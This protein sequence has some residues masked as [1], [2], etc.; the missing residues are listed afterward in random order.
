MNLWFERPTWLWWLLPMLAMTVFI[1]LGGRREGKR[2]REALAVDAPPLSWIRALLATIG[3]CLLLVA[4]AGPRWGAASDVATAHRGDVMLVLD[5]SR[6]MLARDAMPD[7]LLRG[8]EIF[9]SLINQLD[10]RGGWRVGLVAFAGQPI[11]LCP[12]TFDLDFVRQRLASINFDDLGETRPANAV[13]GTRIGAAIAYAS[14]AGDGPGA[15]M[16]LV[17]DGDDPVR[18][19]EWADGVQAARQRNIP[20]AVIGVGNAQTASAIPGVDAQSKMNVG[21]L[22]EIAQ[23]THGVF[24]E[25]QDLHVDS[26]V[27]WLDDQAVTRD[28]IMARSRAPARPAIFIAGGLLA[29]ILAVAPWPNRQAALGSVA[30]LAIAANPTEKWVWRGNQELA[31]G[32]AEQALRWYQIAEERT[33][34]PGLVAFNEGIAFAKLERWRDAELYFRRS[35]SDAEGERRFGALYNLGTSLIRRSMGRDRQALQDAIAALE[36]AL[37]LKPG[38]ADAQHNLKLARD[39]LAQV[40]A[41]PPVSSNND[42][43][44]QQA[45][46]KTSASPKSPVLKNGNLVGEPSGPATKSAEGDGGR[47]T[48]RPPPPGQGNLPMIPDTD[49][50]ERITPED[51]QRH[52]DRAAARIAAAQRDQLKSR[53][54][55]SKPNYPDW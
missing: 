47:E 29:I 25:A 12:L 18:D 3:A 2:R 36:Q 24:F 1:Y 5:V 55:T 30:L 40:P 45:N 8:V 7:R 11:T 26:I 41:E 53:R 49:V 31:A 32:R 38:D 42:Q 54:P 20:I 37:A 35:L 48:D 51:L 17:S 19:G 6:S 46:V 15:N 34:D 52:L 39:L 14:A 9:G 44:K 13:S 43:P 23:R 27:R 10:R 4:A 33:P 21:L 28:S 50:V 16:I 22:H